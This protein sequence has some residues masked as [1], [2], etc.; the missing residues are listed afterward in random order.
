MN[1]E[2]IK[3]GESVNIEFK[4]TIPER[5][6][7]FLKTVS[8][9]SNTSGGTIIFGIDDKTLEVV[10]ID[11]DIYKLQD[12]IINSISD[13]IEPLISPSINVQTIE[14]KT[15]IVLEIFPT[16]HTPCFLKSKGKENGTF[17]RIG[18]TSRPADFYSL[19][20]LELNGIR[21]SFD[22]QKS[23]NLMNDKAHFNSQSTLNLC[24][25]IQK[26]IES[27]GIHNI[28]VTERTLES[29]GVLKNINGELAPTNAYAI[30]TSSDFYDFS[31]CGIRCACFKGTDKSIFLDKLDCSGV[32]FEQVEQALN[33]ILRNLKVGIKFVGMQGI[34][35]F[36]IPVNALREAIVN[37]V[38]HRSYM[39]EEP[40]QIAIYDDR[41]EIVSPGRLVAGLS[42][43][44][45]LNGKSVSRNPVIA[46]VFRFMKLMEEWGSGFRRMYQ[47][48]KDAKIKIPKFQ[49]NELDCSITFERISKKTVPQDVLQIVPQD[50]LQTVPQDLDLFILNEIKSNN[51]VTRDEIAM[52]A[53]VSSKTVARHI[54]K[55][56]DKIQFAGSGFSGHWEI[57]NG[58]SK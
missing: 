3:K 12:S 26:R 34:D 33:F 5:K 32:I 58:E 1:I 47:E 2:E 49:E 24:L 16:N 43:E 4:R 29:L 46:K 35:D 52:K 48:C 9:F 15:V 37:A 8:A 50:V 13:S 22:S 14:E 18:A 36:E 11:G 55:M 6:E 19:R 44:S 40:T 21:S 45:A 51:K 56:K 38:V 53:K 54:E 10:G 17:I 42:L 20:E 39:I 28:T 30:L 23:V 25:Q 27:A 57:I 31:R 7:N 41:V